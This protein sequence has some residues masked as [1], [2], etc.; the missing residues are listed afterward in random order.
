[1]ERS[2]LLKQSGPRYGPIKLAVHRKRR[3]KTGGAKLKP[4][5][6]EASPFLRHANAIHAPM[7]MINGKSG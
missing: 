7:A 2:E 4:D 3:S 6:M 5:K 1:L